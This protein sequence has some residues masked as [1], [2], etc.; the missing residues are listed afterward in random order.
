MAVYGYEMCGKV[1]CLSAPPQRRRI[2]AKNA[3]HE[4]SFAF[5]FP[6]LLL[7]HCLP[8]ATVTTHPPTLFQ[9][10]MPHHGR[11]EGNTHTRRN[12]ENR[13]REDKREPIAGTCHNT[14]LSIPELSGSSKCST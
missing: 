9:K 7:S 11:Q 14:T 13:M 3:R 1:S 4:M 12:E 8:L 10:H 2:E 6:L 5:S